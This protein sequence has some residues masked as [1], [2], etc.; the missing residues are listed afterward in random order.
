[1]R[2]ARGRGVRGVGGVG[3]G[4][5][6]RPTQRPLLAALHGRRTHTYRAVQRTT[7]LGVIGGWGPGVGGM[8]ATTGWPRGPRAAAVVA[9]G[10]LGVHRVPLPVGVSYHTHHPETGAVPSNAPSKRHGVG[11]SMEARQVP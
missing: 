7:G 2:G 11:W 3:G 1:M 5:H 4:R 6:L 9:A 8:A 10:F